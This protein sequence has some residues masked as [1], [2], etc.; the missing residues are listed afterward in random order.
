MYAMS[1]IL[2]LVLLHKLIIILLPLFTNCGAAVGGKA[3]IEML[4]LVI[5]YSENTKGRL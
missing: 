4:A 3:T 2:T 5:P 1:V